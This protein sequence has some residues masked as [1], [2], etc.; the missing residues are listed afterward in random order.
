MNCQLDNSLSI[1]DAAIAMIAN[2]MHAV[3]ALS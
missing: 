3:V 1:V 2:S